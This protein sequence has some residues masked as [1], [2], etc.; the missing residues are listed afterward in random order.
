MNTETFIQKVAAGEAAEAKD[1][2]NDI[3]SSRAFDVLDEKKQEIA[4]A[5]YGNGEDIEVQD[6]ADTPM[7]DE[8]LTQEEFDDLSEEDQEQYLD[9]LNQLDEVSLG[10]AKKSYQKRAEKAYDTEDPKQIN[11]QS[12]QSGRIIKKFGKEGY[13][14]VDSVHRKFDNK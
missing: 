3:L 1:I 10:L 12:A 7:E 9:Y 11:K 5:L 13:K 8:L 14:A 4:K 2:L 6:T